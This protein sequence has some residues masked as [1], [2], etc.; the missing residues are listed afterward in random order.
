MVYPKDHEPVHVVGLD[1]EAKFDID[2]LK[3]LECYGFSEKSVK[4]IQ[5][6]LKSRQ[7]RLKEAW[8][9]FQE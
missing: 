7:Q 6:Y 9:E 8:Y 1:G 3:C 4:R 5:A 2:T